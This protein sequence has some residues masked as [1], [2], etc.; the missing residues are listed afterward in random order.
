VIIPAM[1]DSVK[2]GM[3]GNIFIN[4]IQRK[5]MC[6]SAGASFGASAVIM[7]IGAASIRKVKKPSQILLAA[8]PFVFGVQQ[9][10]EGFLWLAFQNPSY[11]F[12][13]K[14]MTNT[15]QFFAQVLWPLWLPLSIMIMQPPG[16]LKNILR[17]FVALGACVSVWLGYSVFIGGVDASIV[18]QHIAYVRTVPDIFTPLTGLIYLMVTVAPSFFSSQ[19]RMW[20]LGSTVFISYI[21]TA[22]FYSGNVISVW[23]FFAS[24]ISIAVLV[25]MVDASQST[26]L[27][28]QN[29]HS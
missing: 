1:I 8:I 29:Q 9:V 5:P 7:I 21:I 2:P 11:A 27:Q 24:L 17:I 18:N 19:K 14:S 12:L 10:L 26:S 22:I 6:S 13:E 4:A 28:S 23:C 16:R 3:F 15:F 20:L 25:V